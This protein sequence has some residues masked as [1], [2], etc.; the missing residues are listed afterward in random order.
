MTKLLRPAPTPPPSAG[1]L[2]PVSRPLTGARAGVPA[3]LRL[4]AWPLYLLALVW[5]LR[6]YGLPYSNDV[7]FCWLIGAL[8]AAAVHSGHGRRGFLLVLRDWVPVMAAVWAYSLLRGYGAHTPWAP[9]WRPQLRADELLGLGETWTVRL[10]HGLYT[11]GSP[12][13]Y[14]YAAVT[15][16]MSHFF[17]VFVVL[18]VL[19]RRRHDRFRQLLTCYLVLT[20]AGFATY[21]LFPADPPWLTSQEGH[22]PALTRVVSDVLTE[23]GLQRAGS[24]FE[25]GSRFANDVAAM[26]SLHSAY[27]AMLLF[28]FWPMSTRWVRALLVAYPLAMAFTLVYG[29]EHFIVDIFAGWAYAAA[30][31]FGARWLRA[32]PRAGLQGRP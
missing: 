30:V 19:W 23:S 15:V 31:V 9:H 29:A 8:L 25:N 4:L 17:L 28:F 7:V 11:P 14:D 6:A 16:Y 5:Y 20:F 27:P 10:Q 18:T 22:M 32:Q 13:W 24:I 21:L 1:R 12:H 3:R 26:P 2:R